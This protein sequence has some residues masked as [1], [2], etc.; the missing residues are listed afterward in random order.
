MFA[1][2]IGVG[3]PKV[4]ALHGWGRRGS[5][6]SSSLASIGALAMDL[7]GFGASPAPDVP[8]GAVEYAELLFPVLDE[9]SDRPVIVGHS[10]GGR[11][12]VC[13]AAKYPDR[14][15]P[16]L[17]TGAPLV[18]TAPG[19]NPPL[20]YRMARHLNRIGVIPDDVMESMKKKRGSADYRA[21]SG[22]MRDILVKVVNEE[23]RQ[24][25][26]EIKSPL[27]LL[28]GSMDTEV[29]VT[30]ADEAARLVIESGGV[31]TVEVID[32]V[33]HMLPLQDP[34]SLRAAVGRLLQ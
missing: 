22:V 19:K 29:P 27:H 32:G 4:L 33:G 18:R 14:V 12:A 2:A 13:L 7:P 26:A 16:L 11:V 30:V 31:A 20:L 15:G 10:F 1:E 17:V 25:L 34:D 5:D 23:Y 3:S 24:E 28:W 8:I 9:F 21:A 6:F